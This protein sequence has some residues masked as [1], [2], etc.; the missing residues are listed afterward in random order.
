MLDSTA[1]VPTINATEVPADDVAENV[2]DAYAIAPDR[3]LISP[4]QRES[5]FSRTK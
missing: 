2:W 3:V 5:M 4:A 1:A